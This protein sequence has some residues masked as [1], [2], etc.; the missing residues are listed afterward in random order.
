MTHDY[1]RALLGLFDDRQVVLYDQFGTGNSSRRPDWDAKE[2]TAGLFVE[3][4]RELVAHLGF[5]EAGGFHL[6]GHSWGGML[7]QE[8]TFARPAGLRSLILSDTTASAAGIGESMGPLLAAIRAEESDEQLQ[9]NLFV[10]RH[11]C[12][13]SPLPEDL[14][15]TYE[16]IGE[17][18]GVYLA[19]MGAVEGQATGTLRDWNAVPRL[20]EIDV[21]TLVLAGE[22]D[23]L[24]PVAW[25]PLAEHIPAAR[26]HVFAGA[27]HVPF[28]ESPDE[29]YAVVAPFLAEHEGG[30][31]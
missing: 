17:N 23:E 4:L 29:Y 3:Q 6:L 10:E 14:V 2:W 5:E 28:V 13:V 25:R 18:P 30:L 26:V 22:Y 24:Q 11:F 21:P 7:A 16:L 31:S 15:R 20:P 12:R 27:S 1:L 19:M 9:R 8:Y